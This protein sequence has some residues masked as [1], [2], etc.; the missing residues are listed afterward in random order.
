MYDKVHS[1]VTS[2][3]DTIARYYCNCFIFCAEEYKL[4][5]VQNAA[6]CLVTG[7]CKHE[8]S[9]LSWCKPTSLAGYT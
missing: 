5:H 3:I 9:L 1:Y 2:R 4:Q 8:R 6:A 7:T